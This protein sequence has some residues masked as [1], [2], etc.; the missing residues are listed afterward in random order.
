M[1]KLLLSG[2][3]LFSLSA[4]AQVKDQEVNENHLKEL[5]A[6]SELW[7]AAYNSHDSLTFYTLFDSL[8]LLSSAGGRWVDAE[9]CKKLCRLLYRLRPDISWTNKSSK[10]EINERIHVAYETGDWVE[11]WTQKDDI[12]KSEITGKYWIMWRYENDNWFIISGIFTPLT[13]K[14]SYCYRKK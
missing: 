14:G 1:R 6:R 7:N 10:I 4:F 5:K 2:L 3:I 13:C 11:N 8:A 12:D 9:D